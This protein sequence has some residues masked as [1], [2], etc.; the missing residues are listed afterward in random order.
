MYEK[1]HSTTSRDHCKICTFISPYADFRFQA[2][3][4]PLHLALLEHREISGRL[5]EILWPYATMWSQVDW[6]QSVSDKRLITHAHVPTSIYDSEQPGNM[7]NSFN[8]IRVKIVVF[9]D[10]QD[11]QFELFSVR[12]YN[13][14]RKKLWMFEPATFLRPLGWLTRCAYQLCHGAMLPREQKV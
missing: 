3:R 11:D 8:V 2:M 12:D 9:L 13:R 1:F 5:P 10:W 4:E 14:K 6:G 7:A